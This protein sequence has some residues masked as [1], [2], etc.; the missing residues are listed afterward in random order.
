MSK[1]TWV[2]GIKNIFVYLFYELIYKIKQNNVNFKTAA[3][4]KAEKSWHQYDL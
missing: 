2:G 4:L 1:L 3:L